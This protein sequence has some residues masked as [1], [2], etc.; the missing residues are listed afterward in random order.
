VNV[1]VLLA[2]GAEAGEGGKVHALGLG[3]SIAQVPAPLMAVVVFIDM[4]AD[5]QGI[6]HEFSL[7]LLHADSG[8][9]VQLPVAPNA[10]ARPLILRG[11]FTAERDPS[12]PDSFP[13]R[14]TI[15][16]S[17]GQV[18]LEPGSYRWQAE[19]DQTENA[20]CAH[21]IVKDPAPLFEALR[22]PESSSR[23]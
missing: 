9:L 13:L 12:F 23:G 4:K 18:P 20:W 2:D 14:T 6:E 17:I 15:V 11:S 3:W 7:K 22:Q 19:I 1:T 16:T 5:E 10:P 8:E 21:F